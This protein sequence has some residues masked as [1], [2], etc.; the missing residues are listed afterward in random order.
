MMGLQRAGLENNQMMMQQRAKMA[1]GRAAQA[2]VDPQ[3]GQ[4]DEGK[5]NTLI[6]QD[7]DAAYMA[8]DIQSAQVARKY[9]EAQ[10][11][12][13]QLQA[14]DAAHSLMAKDMGLLIS[15]PTYDGIAD[16]VKDYTSKG[17]LSATQAANILSDI[18]PQTPQSIL[19]QKIVGFA[20][21]NETVQKGIQM[22]M[23]KPDLVD[24]GGGKQYVDTNPVTNQE[25]VGTT[26]QKGMSPDAG[27]PLVSGGLNS[28][29]QKTQVPLGVKAQEYGL[30]GVG[31]GIT[32]GP[33]GGG[34][35]SGMAGGQGAPQAGQGGLFGGLTA[36]PGTPPAPPGFT[37]GLGPEPPASPTTQQAKPQT[38]SDQSDPN[39]FVDFSEYGAKTPFDAKSKLAPPDYNQ[40]GPGGAQ[41]AD[42]APG[43][44]EKQKANQASISKGQDDLSGQVEAANKLTL[45]GQAEQIA[46][47]GMAAGAGTGA[48]AG[49]S[50]ALRFAARQVGETTDLGKNLLA[51]ANEI[52]ANPNNPSAKTDAASIRAYFDTLV[53]MQ[54]TEALRGAYGTHGTDEKLATFENQFNSSTREPGASLQFL[55]LAGQLS[56]YLQMKQDAAQAYANVNQ[57][58]PNA[59]FGEFESKWVKYANK[60][61]FGTTN[62]PTGM[63]T[64]TPGPQTPQAQAPQI[65]SKPANAPADAY[66]TYS[67]SRG[68]VIWVYRQNGKIYPVDGQ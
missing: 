68:K 42:L 4:L 52:L 36:P 5:F 48:E 39:H 19:R 59:N 60:E 51:K 57:T 13:T 14:A 38:T 11:T 15:N 63:V 9:Q 40:K 27:A 8:Q 20:S 28:Q 3:T 67:K 64:A 16:R 22:A 34:M 62:P 18:T 32:P 58:N 21:A 12:F 7:P 37:G 2:A 45:L 43:Q 47:K 53:N 66:A 10:T 54:A 30:P 31:G 24:Y 26:A 6:A 44:E 29:G 50:Q 17:W 56:K 49:V 25:I 23:P 55:G 1:I 65:P 35:Y 41:A 61:D 46:L 33:G